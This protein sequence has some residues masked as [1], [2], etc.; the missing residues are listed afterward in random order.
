MSSSTKRPLEDESEDNPS[1]SARV[2]EDEEV[3]T[4]SCIA[5]MQPAKDPFT[6]T[7]TGE[8]YKYVIYM[9]QIEEAGSKFAE[10]LQKCNENCSNDIHMECFQADC[11]RHVS[12]WEGKLTDIQASKI[13]FE[14]PPKLPIEMDVQGWNK[15]TAGNYLQL[16]KES[17]SKLFVLLDQLEGLPSSGGKRSCNHLSLYRKRKANAAKAKEQFARVRK[18]LQDHDWGNIDG[19]SVRIKIVATDYNECRV[20]A[21][22]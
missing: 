12:M 7:L 9:C 1:K 11:T 19:A 18:V 6:G 21:G 20:L 10:G 8:T 15:W 22:M 13:R 3:A 16:G 5:P 14:R 2:N 17:T 4:Q